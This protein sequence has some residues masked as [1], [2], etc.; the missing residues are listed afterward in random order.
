MIIKSLRNGYRA[1][2]NCLRVFFTLF[3][4]KINLIVLG[5]VFL[6]TTAC[7][8]Q[9]VNDRP[10]ISTINVK[11]SEDFDFHYLPRILSVNQESIVFLNIESNCLS[12]YSTQNGLP[13]THFTISDIDIESIYS[14]I[15][16]F[17]GDSTVLSYEQIRGEELFSSRIKISTFTKQEENSFICIITIP[18]L[19]I[20][21]FEYNGEIVDARLWKNEY[22]AIELEFKENEFIVEEVRIIAADK[23]PEITGLNFK[24]SFASN[25]KSILLPLSSLVLKGDSLYT[26]AEFRKRGKL[27]AL[28]NIY[29]SHNE[30]FSGNFLN[31]TLMQVDIWPIENSSGKFLSGGNVYFLDSILFSPQRSYSDSGHFSHAIELNNNL[32]GIKGDLYGKYFGW[33]DSVCISYKDECVFKYGIRTVSGLT[34]NS[35]KCYFFTRSEDDR[36]FLNSFEL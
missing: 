15:I 24:S 36:I 16:E 8:I 17:L 3:S 23:L 2:N 29:K 33:K 22:A 34:Y 19:S 11:V 6:Y 14:E 27:Y 7:E 13:L 1:G 32:W 12:V 21:Q 4:M 10:L 18:C 28:E 30:Y 9:R 5:F 26:F 31:D 35:G 25:R 20:G